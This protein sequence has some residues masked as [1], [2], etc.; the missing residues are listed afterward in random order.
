MTKAS[1]EELIKSITTD[2][3]PV[4]RLGSPM[5]RLAAWLLPTL[6]FSVVVVYAMGLR[7]DIAQKLVEPRFV[8]EFIAALTT[9]ILAALAALCAGQPGRPR[10]ERLAPL[11]PL[12]FWLGSLG[13]G[14]WR[15]I[16][17]FGPD[18]L[19]IMP[20][21]ICLPAIMLI[22]SLPAVVLFVM[23]RRG[24]PIAPITTMALAALAASAI[25]AA[26]LRLFHPQDASVM[27]LFW[28]F[29]SVALLTLISG[30]FGRRFLRWP[31]IQRLAPR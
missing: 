17:R 21:P 12:T 7:P 8:M 16:V 15:S 1:T 14:C 11:V 10:W 3:A 27:V 26:A 31:E 19:H 23:V 24:A 28:Q 30:L 5:R 13:E 4:R 6:A 20:D 25:G 22:G 18:G 29:G 9:G 2:V